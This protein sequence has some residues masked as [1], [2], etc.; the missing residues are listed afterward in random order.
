MNICS[1][2]GPVSTC[3]GSSTAGART[4]ESRTTVVDYTRDGDGYVIAA[5]NGG[6]P[7]NPHWYHNLR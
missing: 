5:S 6:A 7:T 4:G 2:P 1:S 3:R